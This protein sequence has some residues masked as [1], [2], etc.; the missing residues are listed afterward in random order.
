MK[1][2]LHCLGGFAMVL[3]LATPGIAQQTP[4][5]ETKQTD[6]ITGIRDDAETSVTE[7]KSA[8]NLTG[9]SAGNCSAPTTCN[10]CS[11]CSGGSSGCGNG[12][13][14]CSG[15]SNG[16]GSCCL[17][18]P[19]KLQDV[20]SHGNDY[21]IDI[22]GW[23][24]WGYH[25]KSNG[26]FN[27]HPGS[28]NAHQNWLYAEKVADGKCG[29]DW[30]FR[31]DI[32]Y[33]VD[34]ADTQA[35]GNNPG[36]WDYLNGWDNGIYGWAMPQLYAEV[37]NGPL[38]IK[39][40]HFFTIIGYEVVPAPQNFF[41]SHAF[42]MYNSE[43]FTHTGFLATYQATDEVTLYGGWT[44]GWDTGFDRFDDGSNFLGGVSLA[45]NDST[46]FTYINTF[47]NLGARGEGYSHSLVLDTNIN[48]CW[49]YVI[50]S[51]LVETDLG[52]DHQFGINQYLF[53]T[54]ND[55]VKLGGRFEWWKPGQSSVYS[56]TGGVNIKTN[57]N[58]IIRP[59]VRHQ[60]SGNDTAFNAGGIP[61]DETIFGVDAILTF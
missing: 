48:D 52:G 50:Q 61:V 28:I 17:G 36:R 32:M 30:G 45:L 4:N 51:D 16:C 18:D 34:A 27:N 58:L 5:N 33:G 24:Q 12:C 25:N 43:P 1:S 29:W 35:F 44:A 3:F 23:M 21:G 7:T 53:Y 49:N 41:Y 20:F 59:E 47:G 39:M 54:L 40:G 11:N 13:S 9:D 56:I 31:A 57:A 38:S 46:T 55:C 22:G 10:G 15:C 6:P 19:Y 14:T 8:S 60:W 37:A 42:T 2:K 26:L